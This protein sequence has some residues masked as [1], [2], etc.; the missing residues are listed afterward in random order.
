MPCYISN[1]KTKLFIGN[2]KVKKAYIGNQRIYSAG[3]IVTYR[4]D[5]NVTYTEEVDSDASCLFPKTFTP[6]KNGYYFIGWRDDSAASNSVLPNKIMGDAPITLYAVF[7]KNISISYNGNGA[8]SGNVNPQNGTVYYNNGNELGA[9]F[10]LA[11]NA[12]NK[13]GHIFYRWALGS[14]N[15][16]QYTPSSKI[17]VTTNTIVYA[18]WA[19]ITA[20]SFGFTGGVQSYTADVTGIYKL[21]AYGAGEQVV[22]WDTGGVHSTGGYSYGNVRL[23]KGQTIYIVCGGQ[24]R[25]GGNGYNGGGGNRTVEYANSR[26]SGATHFATTNRGELKNYDSYRNEILLVAGGGG[27]IGQYGSGAR[28]GGQG[29]GLEGTSGVYKFNADDWFDESKNATGGTQTSGGRGGYCVNSHDTGGA[30]ASYGSDG[31]FGQGGIG[32]NTGAGGGG[33]WYGGGGMGCLN[34]GYGGGAG[35]SGYIGGVISGTG[36]TSTSDYVGHGTASIQ[37]LSLD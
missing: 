26:G 3:N 32:N 19:A 18:Y 23:N 22:G 34:G 12:F 36:H 7:A 1:K 2:K 16:T 8:N 17:T 10:T 13:N 5:K 9:T 14:V 28:G 35:G 30:D 29:G 33:G 4:V 31:S 20:K 21:T 11:N 27:G 15:G 6:T 24:G 37:L 25:N